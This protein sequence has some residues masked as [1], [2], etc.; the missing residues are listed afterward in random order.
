VYYITLSIW[1]GFS[2]LLAKL[3]KV[4]SRKISKWI[5][6]NRVVLFYLAEIVKGA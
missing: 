5:T 3:K 2:F 4:F 6:L 1:Q